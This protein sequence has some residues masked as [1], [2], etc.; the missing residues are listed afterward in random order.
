MTTDTDYQLKEM[1]VL[2]GGKITNPIRS[3]EDE[4]DW[5]GEMFGFLVKCKDG[6]TRN[7]WVQC[8][9]EGNGPGWLAIEEE[10]G[11]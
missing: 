2:V 5:G 6:K 11:S 10:D 7:V 8:D 9:A 1:A 3:G 4:E